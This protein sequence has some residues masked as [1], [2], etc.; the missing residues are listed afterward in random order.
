MMAESTLRAMGLGE[1]QNAALCEVWNEWHFYAVKDH[2][3][4]YK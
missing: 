1:H 4:Y 3:K 2:P